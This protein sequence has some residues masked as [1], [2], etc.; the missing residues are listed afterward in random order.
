[1]H[2]DNGFDRRER[3]L[4]GRHHRGGRTQAPQREQT[5]QGERTW[6]SRNFISQ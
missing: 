5:E 2:D 4:D 6:N 1:M 3:Q